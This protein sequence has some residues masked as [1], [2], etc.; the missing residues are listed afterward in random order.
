MTD[1][2][3]A[4]LDFLTNDEERKLLNLN[5]LRGDDTE[6]SE[7]QLSEQVLS[8]LQQVRDGESVAMSDFPDNPNGTNLVNV[9]EEERK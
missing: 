4:L 6:V 3:Q 9:V 5:L 8:A 7:D 2:K 1:K